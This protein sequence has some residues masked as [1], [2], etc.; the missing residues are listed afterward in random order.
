M[1]MRYVGCVS[2][3]VFF[4]V[5][6]LV[7]F[8]VEAPVGAQQS[9]PLGEWR[10]YAGDLS[11][12]RYSPLQQITADNFGDLELAW[13]WRTAD[14]HLLHE[15]EQGV[16]LVAASVLFD[17]LEAASPNRW[18]T[19]PGPGR[20]SATPLMV[21]GVLYLATPLYQ[22][23][24]IDARTGETRWVYDPRVYK[25]GSPPLPSPWNHRGGLRQSHGTKPVRCHGRRSFRTGGGSSHKAGIRVCIRP[26]HR[27]ADLAD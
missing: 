6:F 21:D 12:N 2:V 26:C 13:R 7:F 8:V 19:P 22:A 24:A 17:R 14:T 20:L 9:A 1:S 23:A 16:S 25:L 11:G 18:V 15:S 5:V 27:R 3:A 10:S 4:L